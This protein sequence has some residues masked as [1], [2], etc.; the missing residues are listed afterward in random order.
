MHNRVLNISLWSIQFIT[1]FGE[2]KYFNKDRPSSINMGGEGSRVGEKGPRTNSPVSGFT[3]VEAR[4]E[5]AARAASSLVL[6]RAPRVL[7]VQP[8]MMLP[9]A[10]EMPGT[11]L[12]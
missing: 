4:G 1:R 2:T 8:G 7:Q 3:Q 12:T 10:T 9:K 6:Q 5:S 11:I